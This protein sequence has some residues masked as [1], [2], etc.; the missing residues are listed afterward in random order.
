MYPASADLRTPGAR[1]EDIIRSGAERGQYALGKEGV[2]AWVKDRLERWAKPGAVCEQRLAPGEWIRILERRTSE[3][4][5]IGVREDI[6]EL[7]QREG[8]FRLLFE[9]NPLPVRIDDFKTRSFLEADEAAFAHYGY[10]RYQSL[11]M[12]V[13]QISAPEEATAPQQAQAAPRQRLGVACH[14]RA[15]GST[16]LVEVTSHQLTFRGHS[17]ALMAAIDVTERWRAEQELLDIEERLRMR[18]GHIE[19]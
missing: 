14:R 2:D 15:G 7:K 11:A 19:L 4:G 8:T 3:G 1:F 5:I 17:A 18:G 16:I 13:E 6:T 9:S 10:S 12:T